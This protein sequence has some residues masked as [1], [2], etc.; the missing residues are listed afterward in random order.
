MKENPEKLAIAKESQEDRIPNYGLSEGTVTYGK[1][2]ELF[3]SQL[4]A[5]YW[6][7][8][9][10]VETLPKMA[11]AASAEKLRA[12][13]TDHLAVTKKH[14]KRLEMAFSY[15]GVPTNG[16][17]CIVMSGLVQAGDDIIA[18]TD[19]GSATRD[20]GLVLA[21]QKVEHY[22]IA[23]YGSLKQLAQ[24][25][26]LREIAGLMQATLVDEK[27]ADSLLT[28]IAESGINYDSKNEA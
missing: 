3:V 4:E 22:E 28:L 10:L 18:A 5:I 23:S 15:L 2:H 24:S 11:T 27:E 26:G 21:G 8:C 16:K 20:V 13:F 19:D 14:V 9:K 1:L 25:L 12:A 6:A 17:T 7:E